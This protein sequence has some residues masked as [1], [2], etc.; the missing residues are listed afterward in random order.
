[1]L[2]IEVNENDGGC[3]VRLEG[4]LAEGFVSE[5]ERVCFSAGLPLTI[6][7]THLNDADAD[8]IAWL[9]KVIRGGVRVQGLSG[10]L[11]ERLEA[12][13]RNDAHQRGDQ[14]R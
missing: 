5:A 2:Y 1:M 14:D 10:Y 7:A 6:D 9:V 3:L 11:A 13:R 4:R 8:G 12:Q